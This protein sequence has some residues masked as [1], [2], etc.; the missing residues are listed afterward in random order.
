MSENRVAGDGPAIEAHGLVKVYGKT[1]ALDGIDLTVRRGQVFGFLGPNGAGKTTTIRILATLTRPDGGT[2]R[3]LGC[4]V[5]SEADA[6]RARLA[7][8][9]AT[10]PTGPGT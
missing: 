8:P 1:R 4:D 7:T 10:L 6:I 5:V 3:V 9:S 2:A